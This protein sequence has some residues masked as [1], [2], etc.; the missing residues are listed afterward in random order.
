MA[1]APVRVL[2]WMG[3]RAR[4]VL[5]LG[6]ASALLFPALSGFLRPTLP[7]LV[8]LVLGLSVARVDMGGFVRGFIGLRNLLRLGG[9]ILLLM[10]VTAGVLLV[11]LTFIGLPADFTAAAVL[12]ALAPPISSAAGLCL[13]L[14][15]NAG[16]ALELT[17]AATILTPFLGP[18][19]LALLAPHI[20]VPEI[21]PLA[22]RLFG[23]TAGGFAI[24]IGLR[25]VVGARIVEQNGRAFDGLTAGGMILFVIPI[26]DGVGGRVAEAPWLALNVLA[27]AVALNLGANFLISR[28]AS[29]RLD[30]SAAGALGLVWGNRNVAL[31]LAA[32][33][34]EP[35]F[36]LFVA[37]YQ[38]PMYATPLLFRRT[39]K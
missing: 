9:L 4:W 17:L 33:P 3:E 32:L 2:V 35:V 28:L 10:P 18:F 13:I 1:P 26:F 29:R 23:M 37:F 12:F 8:A 39:R 24:G 19:S 31:Y 16:R 5:I 30:P 27:Y 34:F 11:V 7:A 14:R 15:F 6:C 21:W 22:G 20:P 25:T 38:F 36:A